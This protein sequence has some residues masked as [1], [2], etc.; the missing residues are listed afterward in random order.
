[1][2]IEGMSCGHCLHAVRAALEAMNGVQVDD[3][4]IGSARLTFD[5]ERVSREEIIRN[6][7][8]EGYPVL[9]MV[10]EG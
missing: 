4:Q 1:M 3:V 7:E 8:E 6:V 9:E 2:K 10:A 5:P